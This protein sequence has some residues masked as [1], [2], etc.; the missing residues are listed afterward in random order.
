MLS[1]SSRHAVILSVKCPGLRDVSVCTCHMPYHVR[2]HRSG[3]SSLDWYE[4]NILNRNDA[5]QAYRGQLWRCFLNVDKKAQAGVYDRLVSKALGKR[6][7][8]KVK[9]YPLASQTLCRLL[10][11]ALNL[12]M[13]Y[14]RM[15]HWSPPFSVGISD[16]T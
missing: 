8:G 2:S 1:I 7:K 11:E 16:C 6:F 3:P 10:L 14:R 9:T 13:S 4:R 15:V 12:M 5:C